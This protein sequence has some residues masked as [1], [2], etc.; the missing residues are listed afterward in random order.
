[1]SSPHRTFSLLAP[2]KSN[3]PIARDLREKHPLSLKSSQRN[4]Y[5][6]LKCHPHVLFWLNEGDEVLFAILS[7][8]D[9]KF[10]FH[11]DHYVPLLP[12]LTFGTIS[13]VH[14]H[15]FSTHTTYGTRVH[16]ICDFRHIEIR[17]M[18]LETRCL[19]KRADS[20]YLGKLRNFT[21]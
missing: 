5:W 21:C 2:S 16:V 17:F 19:E 13:A 14:F 7:S 8:C 15:H 6:I 12:D 20:N 18:T 10:K 1:M 11:N 3:G 4:G 9:L